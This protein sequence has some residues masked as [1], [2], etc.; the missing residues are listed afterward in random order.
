MDPQTAGDVI[1]EIED[2]YLEELVERLRIDDLSEIVSEMDSDDAADLLSELPERETRAILSRMDA[3]DGAEIDELMRYP[4]DSAGGIMQTELVALTPA[5]T[6]TE[7]I[8]EI[9]ANAEEVSSIRNL[10]IVDDAEKL[11]GVVS[12]RELILAG[13]EVTLGSIMNEKIRKARVDMDQE[14]VA[15]LF[16]RYDLISLPVEDLEGKL[17]GRV[18]VDDIVDVLDEE[19]DEDFLKMAGSFEEEVLSNFGDSVKARSPWLLATWIGML[20]TSIL[21]SRFL[22]SYE[23]LV[24]FVPLLPLILGMGGNVGSQSATIVVRGIATGKLDA[25][26]MWQVAFKEMKVGLA[27]GLIYGALLG[28]YTLIM[29]KDSGLVALVMALTLVIQLTLAASSGV[30]LPITFHRMKIDPALATAPFITTIMDLA[31]ATVYFSMAIFIIG[32]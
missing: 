10:Y 8:E 26:K 3:E 13:P 9:R 16:R 2:P 22:D 29:G 4:E 32:S 25:R 19:A 28:V 21:I 7:G 17:V 11:V 6:V 30:L 1:S 12:L 18:T 31:G 14:E 24:L 15:D 5:K 27:M 20:L 23:K